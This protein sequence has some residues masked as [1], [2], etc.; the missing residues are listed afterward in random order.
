MYHILDVCHDLNPRSCL[1]IID[2]LINVFND[3][4][5]MYVFTCLDLSY[6]LKV[7]ENTWINNFDLRVKY[8]NLSSD[9]GNVSKLCLGHVFVPSY[10]ILFKN[11]YLYSVFFLYYEPGSH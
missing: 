5:V 3:V 10:L 11:T 2:I 6:A 4:K 8:G 7:R 9:L 1:I